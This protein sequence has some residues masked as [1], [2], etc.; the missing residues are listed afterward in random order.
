[1][2]DLKQYNQL[3]NITKVNRLT[4]TENKPVVT[5]WRGKGKGQ[6]RGMGIKQSKL[7]CI[8]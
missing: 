6:Y 3:V 1:M 2:W 7:L 5:V 8:K 4:D